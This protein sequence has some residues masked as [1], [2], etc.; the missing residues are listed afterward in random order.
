[1]NAKRSRLHYFRLLAIFGGV[2]FGLGVHKSAAWVVRDDTVNY[3]L[4]DNGFR[5]VS[6]RAEEVFSLG[7]M[8]SAMGRLLLG[9]AVWVGLRFIYSEQN[10]SPA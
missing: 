7:P 1:M 3:W 2:G 8:V 4:R 5:F 9:I 10:E 6:N